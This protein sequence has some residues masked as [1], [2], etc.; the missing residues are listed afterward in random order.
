MS[1]VTLKYNPHALKIS[2]R[3]FL[4]SSAY[5]LAAYYYSL[6][7]EKFLMMVGA[8]IYGYNSS[9][10]YQDVE[11][12]IDPKTWNQESVL[13]IYMVPV[14]IQAILVIL[15]FVNL[16]KLQ[17]TPGY[18]MIFMHWVILFITFRLTG[19]LP[20]HLF[21]KTGIYH[22][23]AWLYLGTAL[24]VL[25]SSISLI[26]F[27]ITAKWM[28]RGVLYFSA[29]LNN[30]YRVTGLSNLIRSSV[31]GPVCLVFLIP[32]LYYLPGLPKG[33]IIGLGLIAGVS[34]YNIIRLLYGRPEQFPKGEIV[35][36]KLN[37]V[38]L[39]LFI[40][41]LIILLRILLGIGITI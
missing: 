24:E 10:D 6:I 18:Y 21:F 2:R 13:M 30:H 39:F 17:A 41:I 5:A 12:L 7:L 28:I 11:V 3:I 16:N 15:I 34:I 23:F 33:E 40:L 27:M 20:V 38:L 14:L 26:I 31:L 35:P 29:T 19:M 36:E 25:I 4:R 22:A 9:M 8:A 37:P 1:F 32:C